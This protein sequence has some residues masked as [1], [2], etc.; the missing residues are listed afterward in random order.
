M[1]L[2]ESNK[3]HET[4]RF[5]SARAILGAHMNPCRSST[6][7]TQNRFIRLQIK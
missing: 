1:V 7:G 4:D 5:Q 2:I 3:K 6:F